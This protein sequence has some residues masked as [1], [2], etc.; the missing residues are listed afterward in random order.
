MA[1]PPPAPRQLAAHIARSTAGAWVVGVLA[2]ATLAVALVHGRVHADLDQELRVHAM[3]AYGLA[4]F[5][6]DG[7]FRDTFLRKE[8]ELTAGPVRL[9]V[10]TPRHGVVFGEDVPLRAVLVRRAM[11]TEDA[12]WREA[13]GRRMYALPAY[14]DAD[15]VVGAVIASLPLRPAWEDSAEAAGWIAAMALTL[16]LLGLV[17]SRWVAA[18]ILGA[19]QDSL[20]EREQ[21]LAGAAHELRTPMATLQAMLEATPPEALPSVAA[22]LRTTVTRTSAMVERLLT[23][24]RLAHD[25]PQLEPVRL[26][27]LVEVCLD[28]DDELDAEVSVARADRRLVEVAVRNLV[29]NARTHGGGLARV[30][31][32]GGRVE[33]WDRGDGLPEDHVVTP[34][35]R[36]AASRGAGLGLALV[37]RIAERHGGQLEL[38]PCPALVLPSAS[39]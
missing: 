20:A 1:D 16:V 17:V 6:P 36:G 22:D 3:A 7:R 8:P 30:H 11:A 5:T 24:S 35:S 26:D 27:L 32:R 21:I 9:T 38:H 23:W 4:W 31:V 25:A 34:F 39:L 37:A 10:A 15:R 13:E 18:R 28:E 29:D 2:L 33:V 14:D 12:V 19:L